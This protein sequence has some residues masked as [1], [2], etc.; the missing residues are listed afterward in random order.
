M[1]DAGKPMSRKQIEEEEIRVGWRMA[2][3]GMQVA[4]EVVA[5]VLLGLA[6]DWWRGQGNIGVIVGGIAG[7]AVGL[8]SLIRAALKLNRQLERTAPT[9]GRG[10]PM[11]PDAKWNDRSEDDGDNN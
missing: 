9:A 11:Q 1:A 5:G 6:F 4:S 2:G 10:I 3:I 8:W 7:I